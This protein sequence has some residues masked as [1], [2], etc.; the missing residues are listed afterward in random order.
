MALQDTVGVS[1]MFEQNWLTQVRKGVLELAILNALKRRR[2]YGYEIVRDLGEIDSLVIAEGTVYPLLSR[3]RQERLLDVTLEESPGGP[4]R[5]YYELTE[6]GA[7]QLARMND[8]W[9]RLQRG[10]DA[11]NGR[12]KR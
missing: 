4:P 12:S 2:L 8:Y 5:K 3:L 11:L 10:L 1:E 6:R 7:R 9:A